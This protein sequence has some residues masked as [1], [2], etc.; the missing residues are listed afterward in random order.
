MAELERRFGREAFGGDP[1]NYDSAR[2]PYPEATW[3]ALR[4]RAG[5]RAG[6]D[7]LEIGAGTGLATRSL[8]AHRPR[9]IVAV[10]PDPRLAAYLAENIGDPRLEVVGEPFETAPLEPASFDLVASATAFHWLDPIPALRCIRELLRPGGHVA[11]WWNIF[12]EPGRTDAFHEATTHL[13]AGHPTSPSGGG[14]V[15]LPFG[16]DS[17]ARGADF[18]AAG[19]VADPAEVIRW[20]LRLDAHAMRRLYATYSN[21]TALPP[22][23]R[24]RLLDGL[25]EVAEQ[26]FGGAVERNM[27]TAIHIARAPA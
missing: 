16:L 1:A 27:A 25:V 15:R 22:E 20:T 14:T 8:L 23:A 17:A 2:P 7:I 18:A 4:A 11:L 26:Q 13:F 21:V 12:G 10:E 9:R 3:Q 6:I 24:K 19:L 5:L